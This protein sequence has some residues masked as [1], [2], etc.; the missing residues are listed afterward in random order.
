MAQVPKS[1]FQAPVKKRKEEE[2]PEQPQQ[3][4]V[5]VFRNETG[6]L[7]GFTDPIS[8]K[9]FFGASQDEVKEF[10]EK[11]RLRTETPEGAIEQSQLSQQLRQQQQAQQGVEQVLPQL[12]QQRVFEEPLKAKELQAE[13]GLKGRIVDSPIAR[14]QI[15]KLGKKRGL[16]LPFT[17]A[18]GFAKGIGQAGSL[19]SPELEQQIILDEVDKQVLAEGSA[20]SSSLGAAVEE[21]PFFG[22]LAR[23]YAGTI[24]S[25]SATVDDLLGTLQT[26]DTSISDQIKYVKTGVPP[27]IAINNINRYERDIQVME[28]KIRLL[29]MQSAELRSSPEEV[30]NIQI[31][32]QQIYDN[33]ASQRRDI[34]LIQVQGIVEPDTETSFM[35][36]QELRNKGK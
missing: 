12:E 29:I 7:S 4:Q 21:I 3:T 8:G 20:L 9:S 16:D 27:S 26:T 14:E 11:F 24:K 17:I 2:K 15:F 13:G 18:E 36:L 10:V 33:I 25:P 35:L 5:P 32:I 31:K 28:S 19:L 1:R 22:K 6:R 30:N 23:K 34:A